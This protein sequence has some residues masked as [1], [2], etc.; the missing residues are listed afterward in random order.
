MPHFEV[1]D[2]LFLQKNR[3]V[4]ITFSSRDTLT[5]T[6]FNFFTILIP[7]FYKTL[8]PIG[9]IFLC[10]ETLYRTFGEVSPPIVHIP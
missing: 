10:A 1:I 8:D 5:I 9:P 4:S 7:H 3:F 6:W 2:P